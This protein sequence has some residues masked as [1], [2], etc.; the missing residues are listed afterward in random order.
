[1]KK[2]VGHL[3]LQNELN[4][5][6]ESGNIPHAFI[7]SGAKGIGKRLLAEHF[8]CRLLC[9][10]EEGSMFASEGLSFNK[11]HILYPQIEAG[12]C[13]DHLLVELDDDKKSISVEQIR[14]TLSKLS[15]SSDGKRV[16]IIDDADTMNS[17]SANA[18]LKTLEEPGKG[19]HLILIVHN[20]SKLLPTI[21]SRCRNFRVNTLKENDVENILKRELPKLSSVQIDELVEISKGSAGDAM[22]LMEHGTLVMDL[23]DG[24]FKNPSPLNAIN[25]AEQ[26]Q[27]KKLAPLG[28]EVLLSRISLKAKNEQDK[29]YELSELYSKINKKRSDMEI[30]NLSPQL[31]L[32][33]SLM[34]VIS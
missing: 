16:V 2:L 9:G 34:D 11:E 1:M 3:G 21:V 25:L 22:R 19:I 7:F 14:N 30:F 31:V 29:A 18:L 26:L 20:V 13:P 17:S 10:A 5:L 6:L 27:M 8:S 24:F 12:A 32:E 15:L 33:T 23:I 4:T 28:I